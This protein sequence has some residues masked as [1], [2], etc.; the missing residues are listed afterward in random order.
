[1]SSD[2]GNGGNPSGSND[3]GQ[4]QGNPPGN[5][6]AQNYPPPGNYPPQ[7]YQPQGNYPPQGY[8]PQ[9]NYSPPPYQAQGSY[10]PPVYP[11]PPQDDYARYPQQGYGAPPLPLVRKGRGPLPFIIAVLV[12]A[13]LAVGGFFLWQNVAKPLIAGVAY[14]KLLPNTTMGYF[15]YNASPSQGQQANWAKIRDAFTSQPGVQDKLNQMGSQMGIAPAMINSYMQQCGQTLGSGSGGSIISNLGGFLNGNVTLAYLQPSDA[16]VRKVVKDAVSSSGLNGSPM[17]TRPGTPLSPPPAAGSQQVGCEALALVEN[18]LVAVVELD[19]NPLD[20]NSIIA[21]LQAKTNDQNKGSLTKDETY[22]GSDIYKINLDSTASTFYGLLIGKEAVLS[23]NK[24]SLKAVVDAYKDGSKSISSNAQYTAALAKLPADRSMTIY[25]DGAKFAS[26]ASVAVDEASKDSPMMARSF[27]SM[28]SMYDQL[29]NQNN[30]A[31]ISVA[32]QP[33]GVQVDI[34]GNTT[35]LNAALAA[36]APLMSDR[37]LV[38]LIPANVWG[39]VASANLKGLVTQGLIYLDKINYFSSFGASNMDSAKI[40]QQFKDATDLDLDNDI[41]SW[42]GS[43]WGLY[44]QPGAD[45]NTPAQGGFV[46][47]V[48]DNKDKATASIQ[49]INQALK[50]KKLVNTGDQYGNKLSEQQVAGST[51][52]KF[53]NDYSAVY[54]GIV[55]DYFFITSNT[56][57]MQAIANGKGG[58]TDSANYK[59]A[60]TNALTNNTAV[61][62]VNFQAI[63]EAVEKMMSNGNSSSTASYNKDVKP[64]LV[65]FRSLG[66]TGD[67]AN[68]LQHSVIFIDIEK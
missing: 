44:I 37:S 66:I 54:Y 32:A 51:V 64:F 29:K 10:P 41:L 59:G 9:G 63:R 46:L 19:V 20:K 45:A 2:Y 14:D 4:G 24:D 48:K 21:K 58:V 7:G 8:Q 18:H 33:N 25:L 31:V 57:T 39:F 26:S 36:A 53:G 47:N 22:N 67:I 43:E 27:N 49:K 34:A 65:P 61:V 40:R 11:P 30:V 3:P 28:K 42:M 35:D 16:E 68:G 6:P 38:K 52:Y 5:Y 56:A 13:L 23:S 60:M 55:G 1:M 12:I 17:M 50:D 15:N 62:Y